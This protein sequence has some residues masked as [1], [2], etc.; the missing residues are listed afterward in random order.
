MNPE[1]DKLRAEIAKAEARLAELERRPG[2]TE[3]VCFQIDKARAGV[4]DM[5]IRLAGM[6]E[7]SDQPCP[8][9]RT[10]MP[11]GFTFCRAC[12][13][14]LPFKLYARLKGAIGL[15]HHKLVSGEY[16]HAAYTAALSHLQQH[17]SAIL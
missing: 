6:T 2:L 8:H 11:C 13:R 15:H 7:R 3:A 17:S 16:L 12:I 14:E 4:R 5:R 1:A 9:C 10:L